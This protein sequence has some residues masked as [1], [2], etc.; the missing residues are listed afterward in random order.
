MARM[1]LLYGKSGAGKSTS[2]RNLPSDKTYVIKPNNKAM[3]FPG[4]SVRYKAEGEKK[5]VVM[6]KDVSKIPGLLKTIATKYPDKKYIVVEDF[7][8]FLN[9]R[10]LSTD[11][12]AEGGFGRW[13]D[14]GAD[15]YEA[16]AGASEQIRPDL[17]IIIIGHVESK[18]DGMM[19]FKT[20]GKLLD[21]EVDIPSY[22]T[23]Q[24]YAHIRKT[25]EGKHHLFMTNGTG[26]IEAKTPM[27]F[28]LNENVPNDMMKIIERLDAF[29]NLSEEVLVDEQ[30]F[31]A[32][33]REW[34][35]K[36]YPDLDLAKL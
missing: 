10:T 4:G 9:A 22:F 20:S 5:N 2:L 11:F 21:R 16:I 23:Y 35:Q 24:F 7:T 33:S 26:L 17:N 34:D 28:F 30:K 27:G 29:E 36:Q 12:R 14:F 18:D 31:L 8:H 32:L 3:P 1:I 25:T 19:N 6:T 15:V 13:N